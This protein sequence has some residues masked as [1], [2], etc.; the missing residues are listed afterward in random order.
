MLATAFQILHF[1][2]FLKEWGPMSES[3]MAALQSA[4]DTP[5]HSLIE[6]IETDADFLKVIE[7]YSN[8]TEKTINGEHG[9][10]AKFWLIYI[11][12]VNLFLKFNRACRTN[13]VDLF[14]YALALI[15]PMFF[16]CH[17]PKYAR[18]MVKYL[19]NLINMENTHPGIRKIF[20]NGALTIRRSSRSFSRNA[21]D[22]TLE[23]TVNADAAS[24]STGIS[25]FSQSDSA[26]RRWMITRSVRSAIIGHLLS[27]AGLKTSED[28]SKSLR[29]YRVVKDNEDLSKI[30]HAIQNTMNPFELEPEQNLYCLTTGLKVADNIRDDLLSCRKKG[31]MWHDEFVQGCFN[32]ASRFEKPI[33]RRKVQNFASAAVKCKVKTK[34][35]KVVELQGTR[36]LFGRLLYLSTLEHIDLEKVFQFPLTPVPLSLSHLDGSINKTDKSKLLHKL[37]EKVE[38]NLPQKIDTMITDAMFLLHTIINPPSSFG[39]L[40]EELLQ[41]ICSMAPRID[42]VC[43]NYQIPSIKDIERNRRG[44]E[45]TT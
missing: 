23:Q 28:V 36:N 4:Q 10:T 43:E 41:K 27:S 3:L 37:E 31:E 7:A 24:R 12:L 5:S 40:A 2:Q 16:A 26:R 38:S 33:Q 20:E 35:L 15:C 1:R 39:K 44:A 14:I 17:R 30:I 45:E 29:P 9:S 19:H 18:W 11:Q 13:D 34:D 25:A 8:Y 21:V 6:T 22:I 32:D 42:F